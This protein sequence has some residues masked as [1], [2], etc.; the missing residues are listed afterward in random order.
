MYVRRVKYFFFELVY[1]SDF[2]NKVWINLWD[3]KVEKLKIL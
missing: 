3:D 2:F 1:D